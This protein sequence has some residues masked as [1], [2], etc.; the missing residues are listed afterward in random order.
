MQLVNLLKG[1]KNAGRALWFMRQAG[2]YLPEYRSVRAEMPD[3]ISFCLNPEKAF[4]VTLQPIERFDLDAAI[5]FSDILTI[6][7]LLERN[8]RFE[9]GR[10]PLL[11]AMDHPLDINAQLITSLEDKL[12]PVGDAVRL[13]RKKLS[14]DK[15]LIGFAGAPWTLVTYMA[16]GGSSRDFA[17]AKSWLWSA[18]AQ[19]KALFSLLEEAVIRL[20]VLQ[21][22][23][24][25]DVLMLFDSWAG[26]VPDALR[27]DFVI[28]PA[29]RIID[30]V[31]D[32]GIAQPIICFPKG[33]GEG[34]LGF[35]DQVPCQGLGIDQHTNLA[36]AA[37]NLPENLVLQGNMDPLA[38]AAGGAPMRAELDRILA[39]MAGRSHIFNLGH[40]FVP[41]TPVE[42]VAEL[43]QLVRE[44][45]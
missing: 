31:R 8:L 38:V 11:D 45:G 22:R 1:D 7:W 26:A 2:R 13:T 42:N 33:L 37:E 5:I 14:T 29:I 21:A 28:N 20:L 9:A 36:W 24:G 41:H 34:L 39:A 10:G 43:T 23:A 35:A 32:Q 44:R 18:R 25:A 16:E 27:E 17:K 12:S 15:A 4:E 19:T 40:G 30:G 3:F 6:P